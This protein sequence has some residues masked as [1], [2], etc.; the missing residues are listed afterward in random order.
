[1]HYNFIKNATIFSHWP[2]RKTHKKCTFAHFQASWRAFY[3]TRVFLP[4]FRHPGVFGEAVSIG[5]KRQS[6]AHVR[7][8]FNQRPR[9]KASEEM[10]PAR[11]ISSL[12]SAT[13][14]TVLAR[15]PVATP[16]SRASA[17]CGDSA[18]HASAAVN[19]AGSPL[20]LALVTAGKIQLPQPRQ[21]HGMVG[22]R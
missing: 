2:C 4:A 9:S 18:C 19:A 8:R 15:P 22:T 16:A 7:T 6:N 10:G 13:F 3:W 20:R 14:T 1:M 12:P 17:T 5:F 11:R 21:R